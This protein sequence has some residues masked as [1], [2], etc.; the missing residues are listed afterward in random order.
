MAGRT[1]SP[2]FQ[3]GQIGRLKIKNRLVRSATAWVAAT[4]QGEVTDVMLEMYR[5]LAAG[6]TGLIITGHAG[7]HPA[8]IAGKHMLQMTRDALIP[9]A[10]RIVEAVRETDPECRVVMQL[11]HVGRQ[12]MPHHTDREPVA[13][14][15]V[16]D[17]LFE[18]TP[19]ALNV[20]E[21][22]EIIDCFAAGIRRAQEAGFD[23]AQLHAA[24]GWLLSTFLS[25]RTNQREDDFG[26]STEK[27]TRIFKEIHDRARKHVGED[28]PMMVK[29]NSREFLPDAMDVEE[30]G[31]TAAM[32]EK[33]GFAAVEISGGMWEA[34]TLPQEAL[35]WKPVPVP[36]AHVG[37]SS[38]EEEAYFLPGAKAVKQCVD[39]PVI[40]V[41]GLKSISRI[42]EIL[43]SGSADFFAMCRP[44][45]RQPDLP[46][47]WLADERFDTADC[48]SC[49]QCLP[50]GDEPTRCRA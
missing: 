39:I 48:L 3:P 38:K 37:I 32:L 33:I 20:D 24:H 42:E 8:G 4:E 15:P 23:G 9:S 28:F 22:D 44:L 7:V 25:P 13:P 5:T 30:A 17:T 45:I 16:F 40:L 19:R 35:G 10:A 49:N 26:G 34:L 18:R 2:A 46:N 47:R 1:D 6:G 11:N 41:G 31:R 21:I 14:S 50:A 29:M 43:A 12:I 36:E 27:R